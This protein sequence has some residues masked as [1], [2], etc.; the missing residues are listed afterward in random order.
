MTDLTFIE[1]GNP[2]FLQ[3]NFINFDKRQKA[4]LVLA[5]ME[6]FQKKKYAFT[7]LQPIQHYFLTEINR[8]AI[9]KEH[10]L[11]ERSNALEPAI[12]EVED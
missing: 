10:E 5:E 9:S 8:F 12:L 3:N 6:K 2:N 11:Y 4:A 1:I 7:I